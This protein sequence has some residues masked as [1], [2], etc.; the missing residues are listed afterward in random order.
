M[1]NDKSEHVTLVQF[2]ETVENI[3]DDVSIYGFWI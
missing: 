3:N 1:I 2:M